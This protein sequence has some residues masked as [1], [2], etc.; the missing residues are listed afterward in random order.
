[1]REAGYHNGRKLGTF[2]KLVRKGT[3]E[4]SELWGR[5]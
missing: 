1:M 4:Q 5:G 3:P 2:A